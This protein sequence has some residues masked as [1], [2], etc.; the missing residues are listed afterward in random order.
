MRDTS[1]EVE[2]LYRR[3][4]LARSPADRLAMA[5]DMFTT[6]RALAIAG[7]RATSSTHLDG[8]LLKK[9]LLRRL[10][11]LDSSRQE[12]EKIESKLGAT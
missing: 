10:Y 1:P 4:L 7:L 2:Q 9:A 8:L 6:G 3:I 5:C 12:I 11:S